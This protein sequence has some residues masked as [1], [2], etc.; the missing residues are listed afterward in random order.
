MVA[1]ARIFLIDSRILSGEWPDCTIPAQPLQSARD[2]ASS[3]P[4]REPSRPAWNLHFALSIF[5]RRLEVKPDDG[6]CWQERSR[7]PLLV[8]LPA[9]IQRREAAALQ[10]LPPN[11]LDGHF[12]MTRNLLYWRLYGA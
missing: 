5:G 9:R 12:Q 11:A 10:E 3:D 1:T 2:S 6:Y 7:A 8:A 4:A